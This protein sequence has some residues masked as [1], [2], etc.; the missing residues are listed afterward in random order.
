M[1]VALC[2]FAC[3]GPRSCCALSQP[4][5]ALH[6]LP[7]SRSA[8][9]LRRRLA[10]S[11]YGSAGGWPAP[12]PAH[13]THAQCSAPR[14][15]AAHTSARPPPAPPFNEEKALPIWKVRPREGQAARGR[16]G[17]GH[18]GHG[19]DGGVLEGRVAAAGEVAAISRERRAETTALEAKAASQVPQPAA[20][21]TGAGQFVS[22]GRTNAAI[23][24]WA[25]I[26]L[27]GGAGRAFTCH[28]PQLGRVGHVGHAKRM[29]AR[30][31]AQLERLSRSPCLWAATPVAVKRARCQVMWCAEAEGSGRRASR[32]GGVQEAGQSAPPRS[33]LD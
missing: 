3:E 12:C 1:R 32:A 25:D 11:A 23:A 24:R 6:A 33:R 7:H 13:G 29:D 27:A 2:R 8:G 4:P 17:G 15:A 14:R 21:G 10:R 19:R 28:S 16:E 20:Q 31:L 18:V 30:A 9:A 26:A 22:G 5:R